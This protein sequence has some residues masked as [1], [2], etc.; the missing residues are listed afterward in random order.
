MSINV[1]PG[2]GDVAI[3]LQDEEFTLKC[4]LSAAMALSAVDGGIIRMTNRVRDFDVGVYI[5]IISIG[6]GKNK[7]KDI[8]ERVYSNGMLDL[9]VPLIHYLTNL[10]NGGKP[11]EEVSDEKEENADPLA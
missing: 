11:F 3:K 9:Q 5:T 8:A 6:L 1:N 4:S 7:P 10:A 2:A